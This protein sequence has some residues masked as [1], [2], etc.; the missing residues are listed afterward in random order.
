MLPLGP[1]VGP[2]ADPQD[3]AFIALLGSSCH[4]FPHVLKCEG[5]AIGVLLKGV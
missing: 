2:Q 1:P 4:Q 3:P 5:G